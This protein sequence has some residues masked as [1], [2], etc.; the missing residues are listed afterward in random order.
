MALLYQPRARSVVMCDFGTGFVAPEMVKVRPVIVLAKHRDNAQLVTVVP[1]STTS[2]T[3]VRPYH[4]QLGANPLPGKTVLSWVKCDM[5]V[6][7]ALHR[8]D[9][10]KAG[11]RQYVVPEIPESEFAAIKTC[12]AAALGLVIHGP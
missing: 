3:V 4:H 9:R 8:L 11:K 1:V 12:V 6:T 5:V 2:P 7:V 10:I